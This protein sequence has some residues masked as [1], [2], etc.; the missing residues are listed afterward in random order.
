MGLASKAIVLNAD[1][2][3]RAEM[4]ETGAHMREHRKPG[5]D[6]RRSPPLA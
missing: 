3:M 5:T 4:S 6:H 2:G 1:K